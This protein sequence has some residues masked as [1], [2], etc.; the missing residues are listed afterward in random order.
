MKLD[1]KALAKVLG[2]E[3]KLNTQLCRAQIA[4]FEAALAGEAPVLVA[5]TQ[6][7]PLFAET[8]AEKFPDAAITYTNIRERAGWSKQGPRAMPK[9]LAL[10]AEAG[11]DQP[12]TPTVSMESGGEVL[13]YGKDGDA[14][15]AAARLAGRMGVTCL[16]MPGADIAPP[17]VTEFAIFSG[18]IAGLQGH[19]GNF[20]LAIEK[21]AQASPSARAA[22][23]FSGAD[24]QMSAQFDIILDLSGTGPLV[25]APEKRDGYFNPDPGHPAAV[26]RLGPGKQRAGVGAHPAARRP[27]VDGSANCSAARRAYKPSSPISDS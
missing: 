13:V 20:T 8:A 17:L 15:D 10:L 16:L 21:M 7:A 27:G 9:I 26:E 23:D 1:P 14:L 12:M 25:T 11:L 22:L 19:L 3:T 4:N 6:E 5:C 24:K 18:T 2:R